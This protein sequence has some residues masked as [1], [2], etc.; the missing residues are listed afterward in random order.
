M[1]VLPTPGRVV[2]INADKK[3][4]RT[5]VSIVEGFDYPMY[6][7]QWHPE[8]VSVPVPLLLLFFFLV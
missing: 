2:A 5:Y 1:F 7:L 8:K 4:V 3:G 6:G